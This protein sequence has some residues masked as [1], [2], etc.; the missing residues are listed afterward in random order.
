VADEF[1]SI[2]VSPDR[3][4]IIDPRFEV[5]GKP[6]KAQ[7][8]PQ[9]LTPYSLDAERDIFEGRLEAARAFGAANNL[10]RITV[11]SGDDWI[12]V[13]AAGKTYYDVRQALHEL[14]L[15][16]E[17]LQHYGI[18]LVKIGL[19]APM[20]T[21]F[22]REMASGVEEIFVVEEKRAFIE[23][24]IRDALYNLTVR[25]RI[26]GKFDHDDKPFVRM[27]GELDS[28]DIAQMLYA[29]LTQRIPQ[30][31]LNNRLKELTSQPI[32]LGLPMAA[33]RT[34]YYCSGCPHNTSTLRMPEGAV[35][36]AG[37]GCHTMTLL[38]D[39][40]KDTITGLTQ[41]GGEG[42]QWVGS[43]PFTGTKHIFQNIGDGTLFHSGTLA[44]R[45]AIAANAN[46]TYKILWNSAVAMTGGQDPEVQMPVWQLTHLLRAEGVGKII[47]TTVDVHGYPP[48]A[49]WADGVEVWDRD[50]I[51]DAQSVLRDSGGVSIL[52]HDQYC[53]AEL[54]RKR[55]RGLMPEPATRVFINEAVCEGCGDCGEKS[56][57]LSVFPVDTE[58]GRKT[59]I[60]QSSCNKDYSCLK[61]DC[62]A[63]I[64]V[65]PAQAETK[66][67]K[68]L[69]EVDITLP[70]P[71][72]RVSDE[73][74]LYMMGIG[75]T[76]V[77]TVNQILGTAAVIDNKIIT[78]L[79]QTGLSQKGGPV[80]GHLKIMDGLDDTA[81]KISR[82]A[83][84][85][86]IAFD[87]LSATNPDNLKH[88]AP[89]KT[90]AVVS[91]SVVPTGQ[92][93][94]SKEVPFPASN[95][96]HKSIDQF[97]NPAHNVYF[98]AIGLSEALFGS[99]MPA[100]IM[101]IGAAYQL[102]LIPISAEAI[103]QAITLNGV[104][105]KANV[106]AFRVGR[107]IVVEPD[108]VP[109][110][111]TKRQG[112]LDYT[113]ALTDEARALIDSVGASDDLLS[114]LEIR[115][116][117]LVAYQNAAYA[118]QYVEDVARVY[119]AE[120]AAVPGQAKITEAYAFYLFKLMAYKDEYEVARLSLKSNVQDEIAEQFGASAKIA[121]RLHPPFMRAL[122][123][124]SKL[125]LGRWFEPGF[126][127]LK[128]MKALRGTPLDVFGYAKVRRIERQ[129]IGEYRDLVESAVQK[130][131]PG[132]L[133]AVLQLA[134][135]PDLIR[136]YEDIKLNNVEKFRRAASALKL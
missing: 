91:S 42:A 132:N 40:V 100:N 33:S 23:T 87:V 19:L 118:R 17:D 48:D 25:P 15:S 27:Y 75:G 130:L 56:N 99:H 47:V 9:L 7:Q 84:D 49:N 16:D 39:R 116:P 76:G 78:S 101:L 136:G 36:A 80:V 108:W 88:A 111:T 35:V 93:V 63:F 26:I 92:M 81:N 45:Q 57:C 104:A 74:N 114:L 65:Q 46:I 95:H 98:D 82:G 122:G 34:P 59:Q 120:Q 105:V 89:G 61:G 32:P 62:P 31:A 12:T 11:R 13:V 55:R 97:T 79:D 21:A 2:E 128:R 113:P 51:E 70:E 131:T 121:Y 1:S 68:P 41:M 119:Q 129:L 124:K 135:L 24:F 106:Q 125:E 94:S 67:A 37:I 60:H 83:A 4:Q 117:E 29:R 6:W 123:M 110:L 109:T 115:V 69:Y 44:I 53:A 22:I 127:M 90:V 30:E 10:N 43:A 64:T 18:R 73:A 14:G 85:A 96:L 103:E 107:R 71:E 5:R 3:I 8:R 66:R 126:G 112:D 134:E 86:Y 38:M 54:G 77:V 28:D 102:G 72:R 50:R 58:F 133:S 20:D 52:I